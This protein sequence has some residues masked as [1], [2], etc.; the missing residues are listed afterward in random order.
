MLGTHQD[1][2]QSPAEELD[3]LGTGVDNPSLVPMFYRNGK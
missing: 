3:L 1:P 2:R